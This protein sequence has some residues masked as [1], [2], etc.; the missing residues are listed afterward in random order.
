MRQINL[1]DQVQAAIGNVESAVQELND[2]LDMLPGRGSPGTRLRRAGRNLRRTAGSLADHVPLERASRM[3]ADTGRTLR[4][5]P[6]KTVLTAAIAGYCI[7]SLLEYS[8]SRSA[9]G[10]G[11]RSREHD[12][13]R[14]SGDEL[15]RSG[16]EADRAERYPRH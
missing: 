7:W 6:V 16:E 2:R 9:A 14:D 12:E 11:T 8:I 15:L 10:R 13:N 4:Q 5:H 3:A 1:K